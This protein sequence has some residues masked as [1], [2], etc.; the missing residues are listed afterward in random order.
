MIETHDRTADRFLV[1]QKNALE[2]V[3]KGAPL[4]DV[5]AYLVRVVEQQF[6]DGVIASI[7]FLDDDGKL[8][9]GAAPSLPDD[10][11]RAIDGIVAQPALGT[12]SAAAATGR[13]V[14]TPDIATDAAWAPLKHLPLGLG[15]VAAWSQPIVNGTGRVL[16]TFGTYFRERR[17]PSPTERRAVEI[18]SHTAALAIERARTEEAIHTAARRKDEF[19]ATLSHELRNPL[20]PLRTALQLLGLSADNPATVA[21]LQG[22]MVRQ[23]DQL[24]RLVDD[25]LETSRITRGDLRLRL[26]RVDAA[27][28]IRNAVETAEP[29]MLAASHQL[30]VELPPDALQVTGDPVRLSQILTNLLNNA[31]KYTEP[32]GR[33]M[34]GARPVGGSVEFFVR[35]NGV[36]LDADEIVRVFDLFARGRHDRSRT[37]SGLGIGLA[38]SRRLAEMHAGSLSAT[39]DGA[40]RGSEFTLRV[41]AVS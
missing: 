3:V 23:V 37:T 9:I 35:D 5:L 16:G 15:L 29:L 2:L 6:G 27:T 38:L 24:V 1:A 36:G 25:L 13:P 7:L 21:R 14:I 30:E 12:C 4:A 40:G 41:P 8:R 17:E 18:L 22:K 39:S 20:A 26:E 19:I 28:L 34:I 32:G 33:I 31:A 10:Y 11:L